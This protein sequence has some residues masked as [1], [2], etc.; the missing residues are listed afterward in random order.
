MSDYYDYSPPPYEPPPPYDPPEPPPY[1]PPE[2]P[3]PPPYDPPEP[4]PPPPEDHSNDDSWD[5]PSTDTYI[6]DQTDEDDALDDDTSDAFIQESNDEDQALEDTITD[7]LIQESG[8][9]DQALEDTI[10]DNLIQESND[11]D[12]ALEDTITDN[13]IQESG[14]EDEALEDATADNLIEEDNLE[15]EALEEAEETEVDVEEPEN[16]VEA[17]VD[18]G[19]DETGTDDAE[20]DPAV[21][22]AEAQREKDDLEDDRLAAEAAKHRQAEVRLKRT[23]MLEAADAAALEDDLGAVDPSTEATEPEPEPIADSPDV[24]P[25]RYKRYEDR[26]AEEYGRTLE[27]EGEW[28]EAATAPGTAEAAASS[29]D[30]NARLDAQ[31]GDEKLVDDVEK[32]FPGDSEGGQR[33]VY[34][35]EKA[36]PTPEYEGARSVFDEKHRDGYAARLGVGP[37]GQVHHAVELRVLNKYPGAFTAQEL[38]RFANM[39]GIPR[40]LAGK[41]LDLQLDTLDADER[42]DIHDYLKELGEV[43]GKPRSKAQL[44]GAAIR[45]AWN[46][47]Y[48]GLDQ[49]IKEKGYEPGTDKYVATVRRYIRNA[50]EEI[51][52]VYGQFFSENRGP[53]P[54]PKDGS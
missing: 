21:D 12:Q 48:A 49:L 50:R 1:E 39:R 45:L 5:E 28:E 30:A 38:N 24:D 53:V 52:H 13:L 10:T 32:A 11:E 15:D 22:V 8:I 33:T 37:G 51:D 25:E 36:A 6:E 23:R 29:A 3:P 35:F 19:D 43:D 40:E 34:R 27:T 20:P 47:H 41:Q 31:I 14:I 2:P 54:P 26:A 44:H 9:E 18:E 46:R 42:A 17:P 7:N 4:P 16:E